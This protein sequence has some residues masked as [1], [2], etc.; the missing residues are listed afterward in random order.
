M[1]DL[2]CNIMKQYLT[3]DMKFETCTTSEGDELFAN[4]IFI[5]NI[6]RMLG[7]ILENPNLFTPESVAVKDIYFTSSLI[8]EDHL[9]SVDV[10]KPVILAEI[11][12]GRYNL[13]DGHHRVEKVVR[14][15]T[16]T[17]KVYRLKVHQHIHFLTSREAYE[18]YVEYWN[19]KIMD[20]NNCHEM[21]R[22]R[23]K[24]Q[25]AVK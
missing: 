14:E 20:Q 4:G 11:A 13:I 8:N 19:N 7:Y 15:K 12:P 25:K 2:P 1:S 5:F 9:D 18:R 3:L 17:I 16:D 21:A 6:S 24:K 23:H 10:S 22:S